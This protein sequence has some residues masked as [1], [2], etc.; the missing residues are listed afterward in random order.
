MSRSTIV[1]I[2][3]I[4]N[5]DSLIM[6]MNSATIMSG[7]RTVTSDSMMTLPN[8]RLV[9]MNFT[10]MTPMSAKDIRGIVWTHPS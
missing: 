4:L 2:D 7:F 8:S 6:S 3:T 10:T 1:P 5:E 9:P